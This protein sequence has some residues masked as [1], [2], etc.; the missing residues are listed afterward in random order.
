M[1]GRLLQPE[2][3]DLIES[4]DNRQ[5]REVLVD[6]SVADVADILP[7]I[8]EKDRALVFRMLPRD[9]ATEVFEHL[10]AEDQEE[11]LESLRDEEVAT[12]LN[13]MSPDDRTGLLEEMPDRVTRRV[14][15][16]LSSEERRISEALLAY[17]DESVGRL[18]TPDSIKVKR[19]L[20]V[21]ACLR[22]VRRVG[23]EK[24]TV[25][26]VY[27]V[28]EWNRPVGVVSLRELVFAHDDRT[29]GDLIGTEDETV[30]I[31]ADEDQEEA[32]QALMHYDLKAL[33][34]V[35]SRD[36]LVGIVTFDD[37]MDVQ[38]EEATE[39]M[40]LMSGVVPT[41]A[42][43]ASTRFLALFRNRLGAL[44]F[45]GVTAILAGRVLQTYEDEFATQFANLVLFIIALMAVS[46]NTGSQVGTLLIRALAVD[47]MDRQ[48][49]K[50]VV[51]REVLMGV[52]LGIALGAVVGLS[53]KLMYGVSPAEATVAGAA[54]AA[55]VT[56]C[57]MVGVL[58]PLLLHALKRDPAFFA[59]PLITTISDFLALFIF[60]EVARLALT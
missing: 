21:G 53:G 7:E 43:Y 49:V 36:H 24:E 35:D 6:L 38:E 13:D 54:L 30:T 9:H 27:V 19:H 8:D 11:L 37:L 23:E 44:V 39:D 41:E 17:P 57:N 22:F 45:L 55:A 46:G 29:I 12:Y 56:L 25:D 50:F 20:S 5:L 1:L 52:L 10:E 47:E 58:L 59:N 51:W 16:L 15:R 34:V 60:F 3:R 31:R 14:M 33:P 4:R 28:D 48:D 18:V 32:V 2:I 42:T 26:S 40:Q